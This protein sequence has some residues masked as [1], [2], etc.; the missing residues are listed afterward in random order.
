MFCATMYLQKY[1]TMTSIK[2]SLFPFPRKCLLLSISIVARYGHLTEL[3][4]VS[5]CNFSIKADAID[6]RLS[7]CTDVSSLQLYMNQALHK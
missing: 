6:I 5:V 3:S 1:C 4:E 2:V 7:N